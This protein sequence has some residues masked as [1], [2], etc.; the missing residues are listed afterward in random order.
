MPSFFINSFSIPPFL[1]PIYQAAGAAY[2]I[3]WQVLAA[4]NEVETDYGRDLSV[5]SA[6]AEGWM[7]F[8]PSEWGQ[9]GVDVN[10][11]RLRG[12]LQPRRRDLR[13]RSLPQ[14]TPAATPTF[15]RRCSPTTTRRHTS[16]R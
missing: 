11:R 5:S 14:G 6:G 1:L 8:L 4:I 2:G 10:N 13:R 9:Y 15:A 16:N 7:Q 3:P 12:S